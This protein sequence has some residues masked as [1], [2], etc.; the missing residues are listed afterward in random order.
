VKQEISIMALKLL[1]LLLITGKLGHHARGPN[2]PQSIKVLPTFPDTV[3]STPM[4]ISLTE[5]V[6][7]SY[8]LI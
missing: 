6:N 5:G 1:G 2:S 3:L 8:Q 4:P 7:A